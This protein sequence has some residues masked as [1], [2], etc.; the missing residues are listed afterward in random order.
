MLYILTGGLFLLIIRPYE[1]FLFLGAIH[2][3]RIFLIF[4]LIAFALYKPKKIKMDSIVV[5]YFMY[6]FALW[7]C[8]LVGIDPDHSYGVVYSYTVE[9]LVFIMMIF[10]MHDEVDYIKPNLSDSPA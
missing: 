4:A 8:T 9:S 10:T 1:H 6:F 3:E 2:I 7:V 5:L